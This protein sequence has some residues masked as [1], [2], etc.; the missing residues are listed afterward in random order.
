M[1]NFFINFFFFKNIRFK[2]IFFFVLLIILYF[3]L[4]DVCVVYCHELNDDEDLND[5][6]NLEKNNFDDSI[7]DE[8]FN[9]NDPVNLCVKIVVIS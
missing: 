1:S 6:E 5:F 4:F 7:F 9:F 2:D 8:I 3:F